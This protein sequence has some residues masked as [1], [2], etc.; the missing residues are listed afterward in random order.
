MEQFTGLS[1]G[2]IDI[3]EKFQPA[4][5]NLSISETVSL[6]NLQ[7]ADVNSIRLGDLTVSKGAGGNLNVVSE[8]FKSNAMKQLKELG[9]KIRYHRT[10]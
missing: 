10:F 8:E 9:R 4:L 5:I 6:M 2:S 3:S 7:G 1:I